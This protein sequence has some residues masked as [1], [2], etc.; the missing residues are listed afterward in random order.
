M[1]GENPSGIQR[2]A[3]VVHRFREKLRD[4]LGRGIKRL[5]PR[6]DITH[7]MILTA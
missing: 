1:V 6:L 3:V 2:L 7:A 5:D 4:L